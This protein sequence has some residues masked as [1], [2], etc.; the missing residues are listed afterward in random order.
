VTPGPRLRRALAIALALALAS[1]AAA[2]ACPRTSLGDVENEVIC[3]ECGV[4]LDVA[5]NSLQARQQREFISKQVAGCRSK[6]EI[7]DAL[8]AQYGDGVLAAPKPEGIGLAAYLVPILAF[9][10]AVAGVTFAAL[11]WRRRRAAPAAAAAS[12]PEPRDSARLD[13]DIGRYDL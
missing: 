8:V 5:E 13:A 1:P 3:L 11:R 10:A 2:A 4:S 6:D 12:A 9:L 7:K